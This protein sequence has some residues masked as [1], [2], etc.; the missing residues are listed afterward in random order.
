MSDDSYDV[1]IVET[2]LLAEFAEEMLNN[3]HTGMLAMLTH[4]RIEGMWTT[5]HQ[6]QL[7]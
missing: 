2:E 1:Q 5:G 7:R 3:E 6:I 4:D